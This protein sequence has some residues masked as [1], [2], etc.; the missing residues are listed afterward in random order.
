MRR[1]TAWVSLALI[2]APLAAQE[3]S[4]PALP[5]IL[6]LADRAETQDAWLKQRLDTIIPHLMRRDGVDM[7]ILIAREYHEDPVAKTMLPATWLSARRRTVL[8]F[9]DRG[10]RG[11][12]RLAVAR[13][14]VGDIFPAG[15]NPEVQPDQWARIAELVRERDPKRIAVNVSDGFAL[16]DGM[17][18]SQHRILMAALGP[19]SQRVVS[20][21][22]LAR[23]AYRARDGD[24]SHDRPTGSC[25][26]RRRSL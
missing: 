26:H 24:L 4:S 1:L 8:I 9:H 7:W 20:H 21:D 15:W 16:A 12:E 5:A 17:T 6:S 11:V 14:P 18:A 2:A 25:D 23:N 10:D 3:A 13:Y 22:R 19:L